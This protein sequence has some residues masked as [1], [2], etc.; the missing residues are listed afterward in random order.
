MN[1]KQLTKELQ[2]LTRQYKLE[3][4]GADI[5]INDDFV[6]SLYV[7]MN[8]AV[9]EGSRYN[10]ILFAKHF[11]N[12][13]SYTKEDI[14]YMEEYTARAFLDSINFYEGS[15]HYKFDTPNLYEITRL[16]LGKK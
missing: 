4:M 9:R 8:E 6:H 13:L 3:E 15:N 16:L 10:K 1:I 2:V 11:E 5:E 14:T 7:S 12:P